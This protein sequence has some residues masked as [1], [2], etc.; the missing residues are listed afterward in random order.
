MLRVSVSIQ[1]DASLETH[2]RASLQ[3][4]QS[5]ILFHGVKSTFDK[6]IGG[7]E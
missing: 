5:L 3:W 2:G 4:K 6:L 7:K 1:G